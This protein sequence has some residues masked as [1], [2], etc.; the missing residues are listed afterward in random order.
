METNFPEFADYL[1]APWDRV[2]AFLVTISSK[3]F[4]ADDLSMNAEPIHPHQGKELPSS[5]GLT[6]LTLVAY[7]LRL[8]LYN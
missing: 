1:D 7:I 4:F 3:D 5:L 8:S 6:Q 2:L